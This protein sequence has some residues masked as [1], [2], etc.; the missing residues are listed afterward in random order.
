MFRVANSDLTALRK[1]GATAPGQGSDGAAVS[2]SLQP[3]DDG[4]ILQPNFSSPRDARL[5]LPGCRLRG[6]GGAAATPGEAG[7]GLARAGVRR[8]GHCDRCVWSQAAEYG[9][10]VFIFNAPGE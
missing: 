2:S 3:F 9:V 7:R 8:P 6:R 1:L 5:L 4:A 10:G